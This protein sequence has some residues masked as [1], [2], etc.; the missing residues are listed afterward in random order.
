MLFSTM[1]LI[2]TFYFVCIGQMLAQMNTFFQQICLISF[3]LSQIN[4]RFL[5]DGFQESN[6]RM[7]SIKTVRIIQVLLILKILTN[8]FLLRLLMTIIKTNNMTYFIFIRYHPND[9]LTSFLP[10]QAVYV[11]FYFF[12]FHSPDDSTR[13][14]PKYTS[15][16]RL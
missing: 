16:I 12:P 10:T 6:T 13:Q 7:Q 15:F 5:M 3:D 8:H 11:S 4:T 2:K 14:T 1:R 9:V